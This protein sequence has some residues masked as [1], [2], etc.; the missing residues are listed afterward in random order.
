MRII[1]FVFICILTC[2]IADI[3]AGE[4]TTFSNDDLKKY[5]STP[6]STVL[7]ADPKTKEKTPEQEGKSISTEPSEDMLKS[8]WCSRGTHYKDRVAEAQ[9]RL[10]RISRW[11]SDKRPFVDQED[12]EKLKRARQVLENAEKEL[13][14]VEQEAH[15]SNV[16]PG[17]LR[18]Q[19]K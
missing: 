4:I 9:N 3:F 6:T 2:S 19:F 1:C 11:V 7:P 16:P 17:W 8:A 12:E 15:R 10:D 14:E 18:C 13:Q 5:K